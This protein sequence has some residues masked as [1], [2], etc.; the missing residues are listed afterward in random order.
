MP[1]TKPATWDVFDK[2]KEDQAKPLAW[3]LHP[4]VNKLPNLL[5]STSPAFSRTHAEGP[6]FRPIASPEMNVVDRLYVPSK[7]LVRNP[8][9]QTVCRAEAD[10]DA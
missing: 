4:H 6:R 8:T 10:A 5:S 1:P 3:S 2:Q 9:R 7:S